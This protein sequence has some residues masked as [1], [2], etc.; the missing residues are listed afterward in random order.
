VTELTGSGGRHRANRSA[1]RHEPRTT[2]PRNHEHR[3]HEPRSMDQ[4]RRHGPNLTEAA[5]RVEAENVAAD[6]AA[7]K[8]RWRR[9]F[10]RRRVIAGAGA[11]GVAALGT[12]LVTTRYSFADPATNT[13][14]LVIVFMRG[15]MDGLSVVVPANDANLAKARPNIMVP[16]ASLLPGDSRFGLHPTL[17]TLH[18]FWLAGK[19]AAVH[20]VASPDA[21]RSHFQA[22]DCLERG[23]ATTAT[24]TGWLDR[25][26]TGIGPGTTFRAIAEADATPR[27]MVGLESKLVLDGIDR[28]TLSGPTNVRD[29]TMAALE[30]L[31][32]GFDHPAVE[33][34]MTTVKAL[35][36][37][38]QIASTPYKPVAPYPGGSFANRLKDVARMIKAKIGLRVVA[39]DLGGW[40]MHTNLGTITNGEMRN[41]LTDL[42]AALAAFATDLG[43][44]LDDVNLV[45]MT[46]F[47][48]RVQENGNAGLDHGHGSLM[49]LLGGGL[50]G[51]TVHGKWPGL[52]ANALDNG[53]LAGANDYRDVL[54]EVLDRRFGVGDVKKV[55]PDHDYARIGVL[56]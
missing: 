7:E 27:S 48:R 56:V 50:N 24:H 16:T 38:R 2:E 15:G 5:I 36:Q 29:K 53:D 46:E 23:T 41:N 25:A 28:F 10:T 30:A 14:T 45:T 43:P 39:I 51:G 55:F 47:G 20:A 1:G 33:H 37:A 11:V 52:A 44:Q 9:G 19:M 21:S 54:G 22:Q 31:Y 42:S 4:L 6:L 35:N 49:L 13:R 8:D 32:T 34:A 26:L 40:D 17:A 12:Q 3:T 18:P